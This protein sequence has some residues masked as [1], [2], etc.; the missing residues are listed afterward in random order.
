M[1]QGQHRLK[2]RNL[3]YRGYKKTAPDFSTICPRHT[4][5]LKQ[6]WKP[7]PKQVHSQAASRVDCLGVPRYRAP[8]PELPGMMDY[9][10]CT[11]VRVPRNCRD[12]G[13]LAGLE[14]FC[15]TSKN[16]GF[17]FGASRLL[18]GKRF[19]LTTGRGFGILGGFVICFHVER[20]ESKGCRDEGL[21]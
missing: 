10:G 17:D 11:N 16:I 20:W 3:S 15:R 13:R 12:A 5:D 8:P 4:Q 14:F 18:Y 7:P 6:S 2:K 21:G 9:S 19:S 1:T